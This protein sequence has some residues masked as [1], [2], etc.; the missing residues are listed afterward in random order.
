[1]SS[2]EINGK[3]WRDMNFGERLLSIFVIPF[4]ALICVM[5][6]LVIVVIIVLGVGIFLIAIPI[7]LF[8]ALLLALFSK[9]RKRG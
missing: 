4:I 9:R 6:V 2:L 1:M 8:L 5:F 3:D 7:V